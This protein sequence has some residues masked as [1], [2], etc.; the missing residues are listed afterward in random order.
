ML[1]RLQPKLITHVTSKAIRLLIK[2]IDLRFEL[3]PGLPKIERKKHFRNY[4]LTV[5]YFS[6][7]SHLGTTVEPLFLQMQLFDVRDRRRLSEVH[8]VYLEYNPTMLKENEKA[9]DETRTQ[10]CILTIDAPSKDIFL[11]VRLFGILRPDESPSESY[12]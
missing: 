9:G 7:F 8:Y 12:W 3:P 11:V 5:F 2:P 1:P 4:F 10:Q 6:L